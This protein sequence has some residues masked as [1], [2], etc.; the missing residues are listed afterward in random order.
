[1]VSD[2]IEGPA[3]SED[4]P[5]DADGMSLEGLVQDSP[6]EL[7]TGAPEAAGSIEVCNYIEVAVTHCSAVTVVGCRLLALFVSA[8]LLRLC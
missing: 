1:M 7:Q 2:T 3:E 5:R 8:C 6:R 4:V